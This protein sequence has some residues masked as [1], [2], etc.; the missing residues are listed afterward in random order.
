MLL[1]RMVADMPV[2][3]KLETRGLAEYLEA[4][5]KAGHDVDAVA[6]EALED[7]SEILLAGMQKRVPKDKHNLEHTLAI[8]GPNQDGNFHF[9]EVGLLGKGPHKADA[10]TA[11]YGT[12]QE[13]GTSSMAAQPY[14]R[15][16]IDRDM[17]KARKAMREVFKKFMSSFE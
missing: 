11:R 17:S 8:D 15:P 4:V 5:A 1:K 12:A 3:S 7:G 10:D 6:A 13:Y 16:T 2:K 14:V 9:I